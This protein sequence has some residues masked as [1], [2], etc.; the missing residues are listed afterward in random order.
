MTNYNMAE[1]YA[2]TISQEGDCCGGD[3]RQFLEIRTEDGGGGMYW[4]LSTERWA[5][6][7]LKEFVSVLE[8]VVKKTRELL[9]EK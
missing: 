2:C 5:V 6:D 3:S 4:V 8:K 1:D 7:D 9:C